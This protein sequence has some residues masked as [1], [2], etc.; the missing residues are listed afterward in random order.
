[1]SSMCASS[2]NPPRGTKKRFRDKLNISLDYNFKS[3]DHGIHI[4]TK[5]DG[6]VASVDFIEDLCKDIRCRGCREF[7][8]CEPLFGGKGIGK[9]YMVQC[10]SC[11]YVYRDCKPE[12]K[13]FSNH[14]LAVISEMLSLDVGLEGYRKIS[15]ALGLESDL[16]QVQFGKLRDQVYLMQMELFHHNK[17]ITHQVL[18]AFYKKY[19][20]NR[21]E[22]LGNG[23]FKINPVVS[24]D[25][26]YSE[27]GYHGRYC[28]SFIIDH[29]TG[30][31]IDFNAMEKCRACDEKNTS[32]TSC[33]RENVYEDSFLDKDQLIPREMHHGSSG[34]MEG[35]NALILFKR[36]LTINPNIKFQYLE[37]ISDGDCKIYSKIKDAY[38]DDMGRVISIFKYECWNHI[39]KT[40]RNKLNEW[41]NRYS[42][43]RKT[44]EKIPPTPLEKVRKQNAEN[45]NNLKK[46][47][48]KPGQTKIQTFFE[49]ITN[50]GKAGPTVEI[51]DQLESASSDKIT[52]A[53]TNADTDAQCFF[54]E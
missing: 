36:A 50:K 54:I 3:S 37:Y 29:Y 26:T 34:T 35:E 14:N 2:V 48:V 6:A 18:L 39:L 45:N 32:A 1:M 4:K 43:L 10:T 22:D 49:P 11:D 13:G 8:T 33:K 12:T 16:T 20:P 25:G 15:R 44:P 41:S 52:V 40:W 38:K 53:G 23:K 19:L 28:V 24:V 17:E 7:G 42:C 21:V 51:S 31:V 27:R 5:K 30:L 47:A 9:Y 46:A